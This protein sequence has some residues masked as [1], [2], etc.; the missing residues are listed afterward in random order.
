M[1]LDALFTL[2]LL[3]VV[4][5]IAVIVTGAAYFTLRNRR[6]QR[7]TGHRAEQRTPRR[8]RP[9]TEQ[10][11]APPRERHPISRRGGSSTRAWV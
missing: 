10:L 9:A 11:T 1:T 3:L 6:I 8:E 4:A 5:V 7:E 2:E